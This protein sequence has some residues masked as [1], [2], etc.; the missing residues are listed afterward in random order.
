MFKLFVF[1]AILAFAFAAPA[2]E[3]KPQILI[4]S[5]VPVASVYSAGLTVPAATYTATGVVSPVIAP[6]VVLI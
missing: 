6:G 3:P 1:A 5:A 2:P 4:S